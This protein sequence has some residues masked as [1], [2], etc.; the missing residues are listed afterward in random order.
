MPDPSKKAGV[1]LPENVEA[2]LRLPQRTAVL[3][4]LTMLNPLADP[5]FD[6]LTRLAASLFEAPVAL[7]TMVEV[8]RQLFKSSFGT[9]LTETPGQ[10]SFCAH[11]VE[12]GEDVMVV[13]D[14]T[15]DARFAANPLVTGEPGLRFYAGAPIAVYG[16]RIGSICVL[17][18]KVHQRPAPEKLDQLCSLAALAS[19][20]FALK[21]G[22]RT[23]DLARAA[24]A[25]E[26]KRRAIALEAASLASWVWDVRTGVVECDE[27]LPVLFNL[28]PATQLRARDFFVSIDEQDIRQTVER[29]RQA[30]TESDD[31]SGE[32]RVKGAVPP[33]WLAARGRV[34]ERDADGRPLLVF[35]VNYDI[36]ARRTAED[37][38]R[39]MLREL[40][41]RVKNTL[42]TVQALASQ[43]V[44]HAADPRQF[45]DAFSARLHAL[46][47]AHGLLSDHEWRGIGLR[48]LIGL[49]IAPYDNTGRIALSGP[50]VFLSPDQALGLGMILHE[51]ASNALSYGSL[52]EPAGGVQLSWR[53]DG[54]AGHKAIRLV[55]HEQGG[56]PVE[57]PRRQG[58]GSILIRRSLSKVIDSSVT[59]EFLP[60]GVRAEILMPVPAEGAA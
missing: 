52:S 5:D 55:W 13:E 35:G 32:Y 19:S 26:E 25:R 58:F 30:F 22:S 10:V 42:A 15:M 37:G 48:A 11:A 17:D 33:R 12:S 51:L 4:R 21:D 40:N 44:R 39:L 49:E 28:P 34:V 29:F 54:E 23:G 59:H 20:L 31:Y 60:E 9:E 6:R 47:L 50:D 43:T 3:S 56:P 53:I 2:Y 46:G 7:V 57:Q 38:Q 24:L 41:H 18:T 8:E 27:S 14:A 16:Q 45:L 1:G 36:T